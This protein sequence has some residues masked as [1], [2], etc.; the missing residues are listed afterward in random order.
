[1]AS[2]FISLLRANHPEPQFKDEAQALAQLL[3]DTAIRKGDQVWF[4][5]LPKVGF[6]CKTSAG[7]QHLI[8]NVEF[9]KAIWENYLG[10][11]NVGDNVKQGLIARLPRE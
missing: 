9:S 5:H 6:Q 1:M 3:R 10:R 8:K 4:T 2:S 11:F 7:A